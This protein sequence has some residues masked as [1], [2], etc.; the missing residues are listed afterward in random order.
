MFAQLTGVATVCTIASLLP[1]AAPRGV[2]FA[3]GAAAGF[4][5]GGGLALFYRAL[6]RDAMSVIA[7]VTAVMATAVPVTVGLA[8]GE[9]P[10]TGPLF[11]VALAA[12]SI[13]LVGAAIAPPTD[14]AR[15]RLRGAIPL[16]ALA[17]A[18]V[19]GICF[20]LF[21][22]L[23]RRASPQAGIWPLAAARGASVPVYAAV[24]IVTGRSLR[25]PRAALPAILGAGALDMV[26]NILYLL[27]AHRGM[28]SIV[29]TLA[30]LY[31]ATTLVLARVV[32]HERLT[33]LQA[34]G[35]VLAAG[36][37]V[38]ISAG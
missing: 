16:R 14:G 15:P 27:A 11:G 24:A 36:S 1:H 18:L 38:L 34:A 2:D 20:G 7:P 29:A 28:L 9:R 21:Y 19:A 3:W 17:E 25:P 13:A 30:S 10:G 32:L 12:I 37:V 26:A 8:F 5:G 6:G 22:V 31:P 35:L 4:V 23:I 33:R